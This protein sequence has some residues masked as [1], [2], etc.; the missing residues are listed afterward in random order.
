MNV[1]AGRGVAVREFRLASGHGFVDYM[2][3]VEGKAA[4]ILEAK[5]VGH[6]LTGVEVQAQR[7][8]DGL[9]RELTTS[10]RPLPFLYLSTGEITS[11]TNLLDRHPRSR[12]IFRIHRPETL[13]EWLV[14][15]PVT[16]WA[17]GWS[18]LLAT[19]EPAPTGVVYAP[20]PSTLRT[21]LPEVQRAVQRPAP[22]LEHDR[23]LLQGGHQ[24]D[25]A[26]VLD[27][28]GRARAAPEAEEGSQ[29]GSAGAA[30]RESLP[31]VYNAA[32]PPE[33]FDAYVIGLTATPAAHTFGFFRQN[34]VMEYRHD[35]AIADGVN[36]DFEIYRIRTRITAPGSRIE[37]SE[38]PI[39]GMRDRR[40]RAALGGAGRGHH[41]L[42][43]RPRPERSWP[44]T[45]SG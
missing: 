22:D 15:E 35:Q 24:H 9:P 39:V 37:A 14:A 30:L 2:L 44:A 33:Y 28:Q 13:A 31:V 10:I 5:P 1:H 36:V 12:P 43:R 18:P 45:R 32:V 27:P 8:A 19:A 17:R 4:G 38:E 25:P 29:F 34:L 6:T 41:V 21:R 7:Y 42:G 26:P 3:F 16:S 23:R 40:T 20:R 11:F